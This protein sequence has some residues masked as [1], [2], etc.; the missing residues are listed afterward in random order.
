VGIQASKGRDYDSI[1]KTV[2]YVRPGLA[3]VDAFLADVAGYAELGV[4]EI[5]VMPDRHAVE[6][7]QQIAEK[8]APRVAEIG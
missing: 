2:L 8:V 5:E 1:D 3:D 4:A 7:A 6:F